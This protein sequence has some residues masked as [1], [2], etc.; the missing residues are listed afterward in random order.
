M[1]FSVLIAFALIGVPAINHENIGVASGTPVWDYNF[2]HLQLNTFPTN[3]S[4]V[5]FERSESVGYSNVSVQKGIN[6]HGLRIYGLPYS[7]R[8]YT[9][10]EM[11]IPHKSNFTMKLTFSWNAGSNMISTGED[12]TIGNLFVHNS[13]L[14]F[15][16]RYN[17]STLFKMVNKTNLGSEPARS[18]IYTLEMSYTSSEH[19]RLFISINRGWNSSSIMQFSEKVVPAT[20][21]NIMNLTVGGVYSN[22]TIYN[23][24]VGGLSKDLLIPSTSQIPINYNHTT[25]ALGNLSKVGSMELTDPV[26]DTHLGAILFLEHSDWTVMSMNYFN[27][28]LRSITVLGSSMYNVSEYSGNN[29]LF[30]LASSP[31]LTEIVK[32]SMDN[33]TASTFIIHSDEMNY[34]RFFVLGRTYVLF[35]S[36]GKINIII[37]GASSTNVITHEN[38]HV[39]FLYAGVTEGRFEALGLNSSEHTLMDICVYS[40]GTSTERVIGGVSSIAKTGLSENKVSGNAFVDPVYPGNA[41]GYSYI[42]GSPSSEIPEFWD[43]GNSSLWYYDQTILSSINGRLYVYRNS[44]LMPTSILLSGNSSV[45]FS[46]NLSEG[47]IYNGN[48]FNIVYLGSLSRNSSIKQAELNLSSIHMGWYM[49]MGIAYFHLS[50]DARLGGSITA[51][52]FVDGKIVSRSNSFYTFLLPGYHTVEA[53]IYSG[54]QSLSRSSRIF[55][56]GFIPELIIGVALIAIVSRSHFLLDHDPDKIRNLIRSNVGK[57]IQEIRH[58]VRE[59]GVNGSVFRKVLREMTFSN[60]I[61]IKED[62]DGKFYVMGKN[63]NIDQ[64]RQ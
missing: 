13:T 4:C 31:N 60:E 11:H 20:E 59:S 53:T 47:L 17:C 37:H 23:I 62:L 58:I 32:I 54:N 49:F 43:Y 40:N 50:S 64:I 41:T 57:S 10:V 14:E 35:N 8:G 1:V 15:G 5:S 18:R 9:D 16:P 52:W 19:R 27:D 25:V 24:F 3:T 36:S 12:A 38:A 34:S 28:T 29:S 61:S 39:V 42:F 30:Y 7:G 21:S 33:L 55:V 48:S 51:R 45:Y 22:I 56:I 46:R 44:T 26:L 63:Q 2:T 6:Y